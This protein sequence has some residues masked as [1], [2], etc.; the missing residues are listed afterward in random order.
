MRRILILTLMVGVTVQMAASPALARA[1]KTPF[2]AT[3]TSA[4]VQQGK[5]WVSGHILHIRGEVDAGPVTG[6]LEG[7]I[8][9]GINLDLDLN[10]GTGRIHGTFSIATQAVTWSGSFAGAITGEA[11]SSGRFGGQGTD[12]TKLLGRFT[13]T[14]ENTFDLTGIILDPHG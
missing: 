11:E 3:E 7:T 9:I 12:G 10:T 6:D 14:G 4:P 1:T 2:M 5:T 8:T 13:Q